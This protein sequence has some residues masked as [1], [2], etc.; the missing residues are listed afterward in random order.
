MANMFKTIQGEGG[1]NGPEWLSS[2]PDP[3]NRYQSIIKESQSLS[4]VGAVPPSDEFKNVQTRLSSMPAAYTA[5]Q[6]A[7]MQKTGAIAN[8]PSPTANSN[9]A[10]AQA[11]IAPVQIAAPSAQYRTYRAGNLLRVAV[12][13]NWGSRGGKTTVTYTPEGAYFERQNGPAFTHGVELGVTQGT[14]NLARDTS[15]LLKSFVQSNPQ[16]RQQGN[17]TN[18]TVGGRAGLTAAMSNVSEVTGQ[19]EVIELSTTQLRDGQVLYLIAVSPRPD[20]S[21]YS[22]TFQRIRKNLQITDR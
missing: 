5:E 13:S 14:G 22:S 9:P 6:I 2:H 11:P 17:I 1:S 21:T 3:G 15:E 10:P 18:D 16:L 4:I 19:N 7:Q 20:A 8:T 12:P